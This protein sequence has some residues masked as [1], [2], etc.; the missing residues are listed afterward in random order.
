MGELFP[1]PPTQT[2]VMGLQRLEEV[3][4]LAF[5]Q[6]AAIKKDPSNQTASLILNR[7]DDVM[8][9]IM[10]FVPETAPIVRWFRVER[11]RIAPGSVDEILEA[12]RSVHSRFDDV[13]S[14]YLDQGVAH[15]VAQLDKK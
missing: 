12:T 3:N 11:L 13:L 14:L 1:P 2:F 9:Q 5:E 7:V 4:A 15:E 8:E 10:R 6:I